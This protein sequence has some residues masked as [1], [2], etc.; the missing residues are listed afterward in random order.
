M[1]SPEKVIRDAV[2]TALQAI[3]G[4]SEKVVKGRPVTLTEGPSPPVI[5]VAVG[6]AQDAH[7]PDLTSYQTTLQLDLVI[8]VAGISST[9]S[10]REEALFD[11]MS[12]VRDAIRGIDLDPADVVLLAAPL[13]S[14]TVAPEEVDGPGIALAVGVAQFVYLR[15]AP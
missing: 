2:V 7:G 8:A 10:D 11:L 6:S 1:S 15:S 12:S 9:P 3:T 4:M 13:C 14:T 5:W